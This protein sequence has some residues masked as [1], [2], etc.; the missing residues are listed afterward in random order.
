MYQILYQS[1]SFESFHMR[2]VKQNSLFKHEIVKPVLYHFHLKGFFQGS[3]HARVLR[4][5]KSV[6]RRGV[7]DRNKANFWGFTWRSVE[8]GFYLKKSFFV[9]HIGDQKSFS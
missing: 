8:G 9:L 3:A 4:N 1:D 5:F 2:P 6:F 7:P